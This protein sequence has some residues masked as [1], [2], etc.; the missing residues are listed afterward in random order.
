M[1]QLLVFS[2]LLLF[3]SYDM[4][5]FVSLERPFD[6]G[7]TLLIGTPHTTR[8]EC[9]FWEPWDYPPI[10]EETLLSDGGKK[11]ET[12]TCR[13]TT[14]ILTRFQVYRPKCG[15]DELGL[16]QD[17]KAEFHTFDYEY[18]G[19]T[20]FSRYGCRFLYQAATEEI[21]SYQWY[22]TWQREYAVNSRNTPSVDQ[23]GGDSSNSY[24]IEQDQ[25]CL[26]TTVAR[27]YLPSRGGDE[28]HG[29][30]N[31][32]DVTNLYQYLE[33][34]KVVSSCSVDKPSE[35]SIITEEQ[36]HTPLDGIFIPHP[37]YGSRGNSYDYVR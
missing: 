17:V 12:Y 29:G 7:P 35:Y 8:G 23:A 16:I 13:C 19:F 37:L 15:T 25:Q 21:T 3:I 10:V 4:Q 26:G 22:R 6:A 31:S 18:E 2:F 5:A 1:N 28:V 11:V 24:C 34:P 33:E 9:A 36:S 30:F 20:S 14:Y 32:I 27:E